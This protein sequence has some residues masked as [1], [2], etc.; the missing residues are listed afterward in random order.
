M[1]KENQK[2]ISQIEELRNAALGDTEF[3][4]DGFAQLDLEATLQAEAGQSH[5]FRE[6]VMAFLEKRPAVYE[7]R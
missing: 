3:G 4:D 2:L 5:D 6:G 7:G 1:E